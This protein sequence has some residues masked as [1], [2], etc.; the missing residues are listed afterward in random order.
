MSFGKITEFDVHSGNWSLYVE[1][2][3]MF[4]KVNKLEEELWLPTLITAIGDECYELLSSLAS[5]RR[6]AELTYDGA[7][8]LLR[9]HLH[10]K[11]SVMAERYRFRQRRQ[12]SGETVAQYITELKKLSRYCDFGSILEDNLRDQLVCGLH[13][14]TIRQRLFAEDNLTYGGAIKLAGALEAAERDAAVAERNDFAGGNTSKPSR[15][16]SESRTSGTLAVTA[17]QSSQRET[18]VARRH[19]R[20]VCPRAGCS[21]GKDI[22]GR[23]Q[24]NLVKTSR[25]NDLEDSSSSGELEEEL[26]QLS[27]NS[28][29]PVSLQIL[30]D[31]AWIQMEVDTGSAVS[32]ISKKTYEKFFKSRSIE[33]NT[34]IFKF[35][36]GSCVKPLGVI[37]PLVHY[38][39]KC[40]N[41]EL[42]V[43]DGGTTSLLGRQWLSE[44]GIN[45][46]HFIND[47]KSKAK[48]S[49][50][51]NVYSNPSFN[52][53]KMLIDRH[54]ELFGGGLGRFT[55][56]QAQLRV[57]EGARP[58]F[59]RARPL[60]DRKVQRAQNRQQKLGTEGDRCLEPG[61]EVWVRQYQG[62]TKWIPGRV[63]E[64]LG[65]TDYKTIDTVGRA[66]HRHIDQLRRRSER[67]SLVTPTT[68]G[69]EPSSL[70]TTLAIP[71]RKLVDGEGM[72]QSSKEFSSD[73]TGSEL[74]VQSPGRGEGQAQEQTVE[75]SPPLCSFR[76]GG[77]AV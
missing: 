8:T 26:H 14:E 42:F 73:T 13:N 28:Y 29:K 60:P 75:L 20:R 21:G 61:E 39:N 68:S 72:G 27:L 77:W 53:V 10:P 52:D 71:E 63:I 59:C 45:I 62:G 1:R 2:L 3:E 44:L 51:L 4:L 65:S 25:E 16:G 56:G 47:C 36:N 57:R 64:K 11:P 48:S 50:Y 15:S 9:Q 49:R 38:N 7:V 23:R 5:P 67:S 19:L 40:K 41:L 55:G 33:S 30:V 54:K 31:D 32:C 17:L 6:P 58:V 34:V 69:R 37:K 70:S 76:L 46:P 24:V 18:K 43:I 12:R 74:E 66:S 22:R 35:Y